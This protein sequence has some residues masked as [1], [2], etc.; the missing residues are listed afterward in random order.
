MLYLSSADLKTCTLFVIKLRCCV[1]FIWS[2]WLYN[3]INK[4]LNT[5]FQSIDIGAIISERLSAFKKLQENPNDIDAVMA[6]GKVQEK[7]QA[8]ALLHLI[9][10][11][12]DLCF[13]LWE[14]SSLFNVKNLFNFKENVKGIYNGTCIWGL[15]RE[16]ELGSK[17]NFLNFNNPIYRLVCGHS[18][19]IFQA[20]S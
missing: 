15:V 12:V 14:F 18:P 19:K 1:C 8:I 10:K 13:K 2:N 7:V 20:S 11:N 5:I 16:I 6:L 3:P 4:L 17:R 9:N